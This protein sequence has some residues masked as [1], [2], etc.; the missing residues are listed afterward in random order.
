MKVPRL[1]WHQSGPR[2][3]YFCFLVEGSSVLTKSA[4]KVTPAKPS[5]LVAMSV[6][7]SF[8]VFFI[9]SVSPLLS[10]LAEFRH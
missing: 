9:L 5:G 4:N 8:T 2:V 6:F 10:R 7:R 3:T 1:N